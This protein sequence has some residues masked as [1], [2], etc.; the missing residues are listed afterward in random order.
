MERIPGLE[1]SL[2]GGGTKESLFGLVGTDFIA[3]EEFVPFACQSIGFFSRADA[4]EPR[5][6]PLDKGAGVLKPIVGIS[7]ESLQTD[8]FNFRSDLSTGC[9]VG[10]RSELPLHDEVE[11]P[12]QVGRDEGTLQGQKLVEDHSK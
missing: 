4:F 2:E 5:G 7:C 6:K 12:S 10:R 9:P 11:Q 1:F 3:K 8:L